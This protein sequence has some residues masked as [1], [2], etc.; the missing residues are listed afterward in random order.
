MERLI[1]L[2]MSWETQLDYQAAIETGGWKI[3][4]VLK[5]AAAGVSTLCTAKYYWKWYIFAV[6]KKNS[7]QNWTWRDWL[8]CGWAW[9]PSS[10]WEGEVE[11]SEKCWNQQQQAFHPQITFKFGTFQLQWAFKL[12]QI[13]RNGM[14]QLLP[15]CFVITTENWVMLINWWEGNISDGFIDLFIVLLFVWLSSAV[16]YLHWLLANSAVLYIHW[17]WKTH[18]WAKVDFF[19]WSDRPTDESTFCQLSQP[20]NSAQQQLFIESLRSHQVTNNLYCLGLPCVLASCVVL[21]FKVFLVSSHQVT[22]NNLYWLRVPYVV[23]F[24]FELFSPYQVT[25]NLHCLRVPCVWWST[26]NQQASAAIILSLS[27]K[28]VDSG[29][30]NVCLGCKRDPPSR[31]ISLSALLR[32]H[33]LYKKTTTSCTSSRRPSTRHPLLVT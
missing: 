27:E 5:S 2:W 32:V 21:D 30:L 17:Y 14:L 9:L 24:D 15:E 16:L 1:V 8:F 18:S 25:E 33:Q 11:K 13:F 20:L 28:A 10:Y 22:T 23:D 6:Q 4:E 26:S 3:W 29:T 7:K 19:K 12:D 31:A